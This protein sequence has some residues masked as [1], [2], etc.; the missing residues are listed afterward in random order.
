MSKTFHQQ[1][2]QWNM[3][4]QEESDSP[5]L[6]IWK[7]FGNSSDQTVTKESLSVN[8]LVTRHSDGQVSPIFHE[9]T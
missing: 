2:W 5:S 8:Y 4:S 9:S 7:W 1:F 3:L 6:H